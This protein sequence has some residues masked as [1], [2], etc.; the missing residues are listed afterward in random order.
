MCTW[1][2]SDHPFFHP[3][4]H[5][6]LFTISF[7]I[8]IFQWCILQIKMSYFHKRKKVAQFDQEYIL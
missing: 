8:N 4:I 5:V 1:I 3:I 6:F 2:Y 7:N